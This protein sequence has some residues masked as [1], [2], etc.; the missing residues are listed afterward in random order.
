MKLRISSRVFPKEPEVTRNEFDKL[1]KGVENDSFTYYVI[2]ENMW[3]FEER[4]K[5]NLRHQQAIH[6]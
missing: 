5:N 2:S 1:R 6:K 3:E 4:L